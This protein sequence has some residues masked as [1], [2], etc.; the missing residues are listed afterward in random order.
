MEFFI[1]LILSVYLLWLLQPDDNSNITLEQLAK[2]KLKKE[3]EELEE[4]NSNVLKLDKFHDQHKRHM[5]K[6][7]YTNTGKDNYDK[8]V[9]Y[10][11]YTYYNDNEYRRSYTIHWNNNSIIDNCGIWLSIID[12][13][14]I[15]EKRVLDPFKH[16]YRHEYRQPAQEEDN[17][18]NPYLPNQKCDQF[19]DQLFFMKLSFKMIIFSISFQIILIIIYHEKLQVKENYKE[20]HDYIRHTWTYPIRKIYEKVEKARLANLADP[21]QINTCKSHKLKA[22]AASG[23][24]RRVERRHSTMSYRTRTDVIN[25]KN[26]HSVFTLFSYI[27]K[28]IAFIYYKVLIGII[29]TAPWISILYILLYWFKLM[30]KLLKLDMTSDNS[31]YKKFQNFVKKAHKN[32]D[33][34]T[35]QIFF[36]SFALEI[37][38]ELGDLVYVDTVKAMHLQNSFGSG[39]NNKDLQQALHLLRPNEFFVILIFATS[40]E[41]FIFGYEFIDIE[42]THA[43]WT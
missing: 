24:A 9:N 27:L 19:D 2:I 4:F 33:F 8:N 37:Y 23:S 14:C 40:M 31:R 20:R 38:S 32:K 13:K 30:A 11:I 15:A 41:L 16:D 3:K 25:Q 42:D 29:L 35:E 43:Q 21:G 6:F 39:N 36:A 18:T 10:T 1:Y 28:F 7:D 26:K 34:I 5:V 12:N 17:I 22:V